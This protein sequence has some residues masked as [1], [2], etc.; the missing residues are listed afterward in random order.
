[1]TADADCRA[2]GRDRCGRSAP[3]GDADAGQRHNGSATWTYSLADRIRLPCRRRNP[4]ADLTAKVDD[5]HGGVITAPFTVT[6]HGDESSHRH[7][8]H[9]D[10]RD[11]RQCVYRVSNPSQPNPTGSA[12]PHTVSGT[13]S[14]TDVDL[15]DRPVASA[16]SP[17]SPIPMPHTRRWRCRPGSSRRDRGG[18]SAAVGDADAGQYQRRLGELDLQPCRQEIRLPCGGRNPDAD[19][20]REVD[21]GHGGVITTPFTV[22]VTGTNDTP[23]SP[24]ARRRRRSKKAGRR[25]GRRRTRRPGRSPS[26]RRSH[27]HPY[28]AVTGVVASDT[29]TGLTAARRPAGLADARRATEFDRWRDRF[30]GS[31]PSRR[32]IS[33]STISPRAKR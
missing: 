21:D 3:D 14:F 29:T 20:H 10:H 6:I 1:M 12:T 8:R 15:T 32:R 9:A 23:P 16:T 19:L 4:D 11:D 24:A 22:T 5:G 30:P 25:P 31:G 13:I 2:A 27:R 18:G 33:I 7:Q 17:P 28:G 26:R